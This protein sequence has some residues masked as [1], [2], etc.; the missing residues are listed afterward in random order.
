[1]RYLTNI[2]CGN[3]HRENYVFLILKLIIHTYYS[4]YSSVL[5][6]IVLVYCNKCLHIRGTRSDGGGV[7]PP[8]LGRR[9]RSHIVIIR[10]YPYNINII[11]LHNTIG[12]ATFQSNSIF[13]RRY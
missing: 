5:V 3:S 12:L 2:S 7:G 8:E 9:R 11:Y 10:L 4:T 6:C 13:L 1:M